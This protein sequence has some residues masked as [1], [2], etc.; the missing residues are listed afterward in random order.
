MYG[1]WVL[2][3]DSEKKITLLQPTKPL[4]IFTGTSATSTGLKNYLLNFFNTHHGPTNLLRKSGK[5]YPS[6]ANLA[7]PKKT[8]D[9][10]CSFLDLPAHFHQ[11]TLQERT[12]AWQRFSHSLRSQ[13]LA[14]PVEITS[15][16]QS[17]LRKVRWWRGLLIFSRNPLDDCSIAYMFTQNNMIFIAQSHFKTKMQKVDIYRSLVRTFLL[18]LGTK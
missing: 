18:I 12:S 16:C 14:H 2:F 8:Q 11:S 3:L 5:S 15:Q 7:K 9:F 4:I 17:V 10:Q 13:L 6:I 1:S